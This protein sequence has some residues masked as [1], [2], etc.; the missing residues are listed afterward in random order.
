VCVDVVTD[1]TTGEVS[2]FLRSLRDETP[3]AVSSLGFSVVGPIH[4]AVESPFETALQK[5]LSSTDAFVVQWLLRT[6]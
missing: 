6:G 3:V 4:A 2:A 1:P 5:Q